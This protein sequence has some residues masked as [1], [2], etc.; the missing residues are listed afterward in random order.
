MSGCSASNH[1]NSCFQTLLPRVRYWKR[2]VLGSN[3]IAYQ[4]EFSLLIGCG[5]LHSRFFFLAVLPRVIV[6]I[7]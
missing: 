7:S 4:F 3:Q 6:S 5:S 1:I 2:S